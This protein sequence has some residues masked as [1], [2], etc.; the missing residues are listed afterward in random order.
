MTLYDRRVQAWLRACTGQ[1]VELFENQAE[2]FREQV[3]RTTMHTDGEASTSDLPEL[4]ADV[5]E[6]QQG[7]SIVD[8]EKP[9]P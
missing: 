1:L 6:L 5:L 7:S 2:V 8:G 4:Q 3:R 9:L